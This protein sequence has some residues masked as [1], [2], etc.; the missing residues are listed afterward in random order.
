MTFRGS[1]FL[2]E[3]KGGQMKSYT[4][5]N[6]R[7]GEQQWVT[8]EVLEWNGRAR[9]SS[10]G[11]QHCGCSQEQHGREM[12]QTHGPFGRHEGDLAQSVILIDCSLLAAIKEH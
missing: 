8:G 1:Q 12:A 6:G 7:E 3:D 5:Y 11:R 10:H 2:G 9:D 4:G